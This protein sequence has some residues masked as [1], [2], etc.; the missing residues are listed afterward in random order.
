MH[1]RKDAGNNRPAGPVASN[2]TGVDAYSPREMAARVEAAGVIKAGLPFDK[3]AML[4]LLAGAFIGFGAAL[5]TVVMTGNGL[6][7]GPGRLLG[8]VAFSL[9]LILVIVGG[10]EL[11]TGN[12]LIVMAWADRKVTTIGLLRNWSI[13]Y[14]ANALG[15]AALALIVWRSGILGPGGMSETA[16]KIAE[17]KMALGWEEAFWR[18]VLCNTLVCLAVWLCFAARS[19]TDKIVAIILPIAAFV[20]LGFEHSIANFYLIPIGMLLGAEGGLSGLVGN[21][22]PVTLGNIAGGAGGVALVYWVNYGRR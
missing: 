13:S 15:A 19:V 7:F 4:G 3:L 20:A 9:G 10:A 18:G 5:F 6:G 17:A 14:V 11:F 8:G 2:F 12:A 1:D 16:I 21:L 22:V